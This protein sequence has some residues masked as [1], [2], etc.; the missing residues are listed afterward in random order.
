MTIM[1]INKPFDNFSCKR[2]V[3]NGFDKD[4]RNRKKKGK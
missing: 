3:Y 1:P 4:E 2:V